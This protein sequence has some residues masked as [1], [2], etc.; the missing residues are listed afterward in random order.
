MLTFLTTTTTTTINPPWKKKKKKKP[1]LCA[2]CHT[3]DGWASA[4][5]S[6]RWVLL[7]K[8]CDGF[9]FA[10]QL[11]AI[12]SPKRI[13]LGRLRGVLKAYITDFKSSTTP[14]HIFHPPACDNACLFFSLRSSRPRVSSHS[15]DE[16]EGKR[17]YHLVKQE[18]DAT[19][20]VWHLLSF[21]DNHNW[22]S[23]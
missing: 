19:E 10:A 15:F 16:G 12:I 21:A 3:A 4:R 18:G 8:K 1:L 9:C 13:K 11:K 14:G 2:L 23:G 22:K 7:R 17:I 6:L 5:V 20:P